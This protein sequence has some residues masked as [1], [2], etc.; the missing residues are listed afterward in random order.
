MSA[1]DLTLSG[2]TVQDGDPVADTPPATSDGAAVVRAELAKIGT[3]PASNQPQPGP[4]SGPVSAPQAG[5]DPPATGESAPEPGPTVPEPAPRA[6]NGERSPTTPDIVRSLTNPATGKRMAEKDREWLAGILEG[7][8]P[9]PK[10]GSKQYKKLRRLQNRI[11]DWRKGHE[12]RAEQRAQHDIERAAEQRTLEVTTQAQADI[13]AALTGRE[14]WEQLDGAIAAAEFLTGMNLSELRFTPEE[15]AEL[16]TPT[17]DVL[18]KHPRIAAW[19]VGAHTAE[20]RLVM[21][22][23]SVVAPKVGRFAQRLAQEHQAAAELEEKT[24][25]G[26]TA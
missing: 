22:L 16:G 12:E 23:A 25:A 8:T 14:V 11:L 2:P 19:L 5:A 13:L 26:E 9:R 7:K 6:R 21:V 15:I 24:I 4:G 3:P 1:L 17:R 10:R 18:L 20:L